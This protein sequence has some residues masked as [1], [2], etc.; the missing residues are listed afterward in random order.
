SAP[1]GTRHT[2]GGLFLR[3]RD[4]LKLGQLVLAGGAWKGSQIVSSDWITRSTS[5]QTTATDEAHGYQWFLP[6]LLVGD[7]TLSL[8]TAAGYGGQ[9]MHV[10]PELDAVVITNAH[11]FYGDGSY[12]LI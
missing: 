10:I 5:P 4:M 12:G 2:G 11:D 7:R 8:I 3:P 1:D 9:F 6:K